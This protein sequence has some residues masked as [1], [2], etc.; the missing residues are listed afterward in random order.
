[1]KLLG[2]HHVTAIASNARENLRFYTEVLGLRL[3]KKTVN[4]DDPTTYHF[5]FGDAVGTAGSIL[6]F[7]PWSGLRR[8]R[9]GR[10]QV[11]AIAFAVR[12]GALPFWTERLR[13]Q[14]VV[15]R[16]LPPR[17]GERGIA[18]SDTDGLPL[19]LVETAQPAGVPHL[20]A[21]IPAEFAVHGIHSVTIP[22]NSDAATSDVLTRVMGY[23]LSGREDARARFTTHD[24][25]AGTFVD[26]LADPNAPSGLSGAGTVHHLAFRVADDAAQIAAR[27]EL[28]D[29]GLGVSP[30]MDRNYFHSIYYREPDGVLFEIATDPPGF[31]VDEPVS[32]LGQSLKLPT[33][34]EQHRAEIAAALPALK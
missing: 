28:T 30:V 14:R 12:A 31:A 13:A 21:D 23:R 2:L 17:F 1:M 15:A 25:G 24:G 4:F 26:L 6:T 9:P 11:A 32:E 19:E 29:A 34:Y 33:Q 18:F 20:H 5:Y 27:A 3:V 22:V 16:E 10:G 7:F 8:G